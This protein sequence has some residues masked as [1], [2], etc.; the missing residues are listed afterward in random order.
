MRVD[1]CCVLL[2]WDVLLALALSRNR[3]SCLKPRY[4]HVLVCSLEL[5]TL[6]S[7]LTSVCCDVMFFLVAILYVCFFAKIQISR[8]ADE[9]RISGPSIGPY[10]VRTKPLLHIDPPGLIEA[11]P[12]L[13]HDLEDLGFGGVV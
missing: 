4:L 5:T 12:P 2:G 13:L 8:K 10:T 9:L 7:F 11:Q 3:Y 1:V 6:R